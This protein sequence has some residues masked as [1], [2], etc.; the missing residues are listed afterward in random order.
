MIQIVYFLILR[1]GEMAGWDEIA[2][3]GSLV[4]KEFRDKDVS[5]VSKVV[6]T[7][8]SSSHG[9]PTPPPG[10]LFL[11]LFWQGPETGHILGLF[12]SRL[13]DYCS[14]GLLLAVLTAIETEE[15]SLVKFMLGERKRA[16]R[17]TSNVFEGTSIAAAAMSGDSD[18]LGLLLGSLPS[19][20]FCAVSPSIKFS[21]SL[22]AENFNVSR[23]IKETTIDAFFLPGALRCYSPLILPVIADRT[24]V[25]MLMMSHNSYYQPDMAYLLCAIANHAPHWWRLSSLGPVSLLRG[26][27]MSH[28]PMALYTLLCS[29]DRGK[30]FSFFSERAS[31]GSSTAQRLHF[32]RP[33]GSERAPW[34]TCC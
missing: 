6:R 4:R 21:P 14:T 3:A 8:L 18:L 30:S 12:E 22:K 7:L 15:S 28:C 10:S 13:Y 29:R 19:A 24:D 1:H 11:P 34:L 32:A 31:S 5:L 17:K 26:Q 9:V 20:K 2:A 25:V 27:R 33:F 16:D 23:I